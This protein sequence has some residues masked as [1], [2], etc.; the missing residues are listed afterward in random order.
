MS[1][2]AICK[3]NLASVAY[4]RDDPAYHFWAGVSIPSAFIR[5]YTLPTH[6]GYRYNLKGF[7]NV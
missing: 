5:P 3:K 7:T 2:I 6:V 1:E 4:V